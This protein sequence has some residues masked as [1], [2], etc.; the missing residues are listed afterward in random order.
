M[1]RMFSDLLNGTIL[2]SI[3]AGISCLLALAG[4]GR[5]YYLAVFLPFFMLA[6]ILIAWLLQLRDDGF[7][8]SPSAMRGG[9]TGKPVGP[10]ARVEAE[11][12]IGGGSGEVADRPPE[13]LLRVAARWDEGPIGRASPGAPNK[14]FFPQAKRALLWAAAELGLAASLLYSLGGI[15]ATFY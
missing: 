10:D 3:A 8:G 1:R 2:A 6:Y 9:K 13:Q 11:R 14:D 5:L 4:L 7:M 12:G 15:G